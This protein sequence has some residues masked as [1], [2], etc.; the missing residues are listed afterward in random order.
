M[1][2]L[3]CNT[4]NPRRLHSRCFSAG[5]VHLRESFRLLWEQHVYWTRMAIISI[6]LNLPDA[7]VTTDRLLRNAADFARLFSCFYSNG[8]AAE[9]K[10]L[11]TEHI[12]I[13]AELVNAAKAG[14]HQALTAAETRWR[15][16]GDE[17]VVFLHSINACW[18]LEPLRAMWYEHLALVKEEAVARLGGDYEQDIAIFN[19]IE[20]QA[21]NMAD[22]FARGVACQFGC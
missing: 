20:K 6:T 4:P 12:V 18:R 3:Y 13:A 22:D 1:Y 11:L 17:I 16:N 8:I 5:I 2:K 21:L 15:T 19:R 14:N 9:F 7:D 10:R